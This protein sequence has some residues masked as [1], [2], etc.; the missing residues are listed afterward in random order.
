MSEFW[1]R[2]GVGDVEVSRRGVGKKL[3]DLIKDERRTREQGEKKPPLLKGRSRRSSTNTGREKP[4]T[5]GGRTGHFRRGVITSQGRPHEQFLREF[6][7]KDETFIPGRKGGGAA[8]LLHH[9][10][11]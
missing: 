6:S 8:G 11:P 2:K 7:L 1:E 3:S 4:H 5:G 9:G 10:N